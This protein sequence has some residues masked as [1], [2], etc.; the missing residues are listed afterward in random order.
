MPRPAAQF[1]IYL[2]LY[3]N[4]GSPVPNAALLITC[5]ADDEHEA[6][7][8]FFEEYKEQLKDRFQQL[9]VLITIQHIEVI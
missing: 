7:V 5:L 3:F 6:A 1:A 9:E 8:Q 2:P 4:Y